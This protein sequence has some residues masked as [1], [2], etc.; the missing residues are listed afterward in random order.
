MAKQKYYA[1]KQP[2]SIRGLYYS[3]G[4]VESKIRGVSGALHKSFKT[5][6]EAL[7]YLGIN[8][9]S[10][11][12]HENAQSSLKEVKDDWSFLETE[13]E[14]SK[15]KSSI[16][17]IVNKS[18]DTKED[19]II[20]TDGSF[21]SSNRRSGSGIV[22]VQ[23]NSIVFEEYFSVVDYKDKNITGEVN[24]VLKAIELSIKFG[25]KEVTICHDL[26]HIGEWVNGGYKANTETSKNYVDKMKELSRYIKVNFIWTKG[27]LTDRSNPHKVY[28]DRADVLA[29]M[30]TDLLF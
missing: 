18:L 20:Y 22:F 11:E 4:E 14:I 25:F 6:E 1:I 23:N 3:W 7:E 2:A 12:F 16:P 13:P 30:G 17:P 8:S 19:L 15:E 24:A 28:N 5:E 29:E 21:N 26:I 27:H 9:M 10:T